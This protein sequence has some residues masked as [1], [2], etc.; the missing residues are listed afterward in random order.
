MAIEAKR[1]LRNVRFKLKDNNEIEYSDY[2]I[3]NALNECIRYINQHLALKCSDF[4]EKMQ[5]VREDDINAE[6]AE[7]NKT[8]QQ[9]INAGAAT[10]DDLIP[11]ISLAIDGVSIPDDFISLVA[12]LRAKD[13]YHLSP[14]PA[15]ETL[16]RFNKSEYKVF[17]NKIYANCD[18]DLLYRASIDEVTDMVN[19]SVEL[20]SMFFDAMVK[21]TCMIL[22]N[23]PD[24]D[25]LMA[26]TSRLM[27]NIVPRRRY[28]NIKSRMPFKV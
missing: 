7:K 13:G 22:Q 9:Q 15:A 24:T 18:F 23:K 28:S 1:I 16:S 27:D 3:K 8:I 21:L 6:I 25:V 11:Y 2:D 19:G 12:V 5:Y 10:K 26:E 20:P 4:L 17:A 14:V